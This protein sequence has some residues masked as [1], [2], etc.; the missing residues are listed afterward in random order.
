MEAQHAAILFYNSCLRI[1]NLR[2]FSG[3]HQVLAL[4]AFWLAILLVPLLRPSLTLKCYIF[5]ELGFDFIPPMNGN[6][7]CCKHCWWLCICVHVHFWWLTV[8]HRKLLIWALI[9]DRRSIE[10]EGEEECNPSFHFINVFWNWSIV[11]TSPTSWGGGF[12]VFSKSNL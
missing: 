10:E 4:H 5:I 6:S 1:S 12:E 7:C 8:D 2:F 9:K 3:Y 11:S